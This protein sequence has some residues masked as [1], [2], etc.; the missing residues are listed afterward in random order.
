MINGADTALAVPPAITTPFTKALKIQS[1]AKA[2]PTVGQWV[3]AA[4][5][6]IFIAAY[7]HWAGWTTQIDKPE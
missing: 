4:G 1:F 5:S 6:R 3:A 2:Q 7:C